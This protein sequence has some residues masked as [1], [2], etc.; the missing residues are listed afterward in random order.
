MTL[1]DN[2]VEKMHAGGK[3]R[4]KTLLGQRHPA[5]LEKKP[6][7]SKNFKKKTS[8][9]FF[10][11]CPKSKLLKKTL[12][13]RFYRFIPSVGK[14]RLEVQEWAKLSQQV[15]QTKPIIGNSETVR[16]CYPSGSSISLKYKS[17]VIWESYQLQRAFTK[18]TITC[19]SIITA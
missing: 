11:W 2:R 10:D 8:R 16:F 7:G 6:S 12:T 3:H 13:T 18:L 15:C 4:E 19:K 17:E 5:P 1:P 9:I 14:Q